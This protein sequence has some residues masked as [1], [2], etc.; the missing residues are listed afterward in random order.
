MSFILVMTLFI[1]LKITVLAEAPEITATLDLSGIKKYGN[2][3]LSTKC[4]EILDAGYK[5]GDVVTV[6]FAE[7]ILDIPFCSDYSDIESGTLGIFARQEDDEDS[8]WL[9]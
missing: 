7:Q 9:L 6:S 1:P 5:F 4:S 2:V 8:G 3:V